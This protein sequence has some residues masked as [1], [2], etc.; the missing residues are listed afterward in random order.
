MYDFDTSSMTKGYRKQK[1]ENAKRKKISVR[2]FMDK[3]YEILF[4]RLEAF[5]NNFEE[6]IKELGLERKNC[7]GCMVCCVSP[8][9][10]LTTSDLEYEYL[11]NYLKSINYDIDFHFELLDKNRPDKRLTLNSPYP[12][13]LCKSKGCA[14][15]PARPFGCRIFGPLSQEN[16][17]ISMC[18]YKKPRIYKSPFEIPLWDEYASILRSYPFKVG[19]FYK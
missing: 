14:G 13:P 11:I 19:Y 5:Y 10:V 8:V 7:D 18:V 3:Q 9:F 17:N 1:G 2:I 16:V 4:A 12:C 15:Y 6:K